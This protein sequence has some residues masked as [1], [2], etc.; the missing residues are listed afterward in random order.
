MTKNMT[1]RSRGEAPRLKRFKVCLRRLTIM[2]EKKCKKIYMINARVDEELY[3]ELTEKAKIYQCSMSDII[4]SR[5]KNDSPA[6][7]RERIYQKIMEVAVLLEKQ[8]SLYKN[9]DNSKIRKELF[10]LCTM[11]N[12]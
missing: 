8:E 10:E 4:V 1:L 7:K 3:R 9:I 6:I 2:S 11:L 5:L 12:S